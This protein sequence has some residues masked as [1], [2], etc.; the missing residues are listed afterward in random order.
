MKQT[1]SKQVVSSE[2]K[3]GRGKKEDTL[4]ANGSTISAWMF[5]WHLPFQK[6]FGVSMEGSDTEKRRIRIKGRDHISL[7]F[8]SHNE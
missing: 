3:A 1:E 2:N 6:D 5:A 8:I 4:T 7:K